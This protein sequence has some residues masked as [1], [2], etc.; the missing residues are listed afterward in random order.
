MNEEINNVTN[1]ELEKLAD[2]YVETENYI[3]VIDSLIETCDE[4]LNN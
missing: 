2:M 4:L 1:E 3:S